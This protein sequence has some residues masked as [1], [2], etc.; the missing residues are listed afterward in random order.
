MSIEIL[1]LPTAS[2]SGSTNEGSAAR[3]RA[4]NN[5]TDQAQNESGK[6]PQTDTVT[7][8]ETATQ[9]Q[10]MENEITNIPVINMD[11]VE[12]MRLRLENDEY[13]IDANSLADNIL[14]FESQL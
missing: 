2:Q 4:V 1:N 7:F 12:E 8:T 10:A 3:S 11:R 13:Q 14:R 9:L 5:N 6:A